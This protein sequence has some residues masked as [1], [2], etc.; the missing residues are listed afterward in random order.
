MSQPVAARIN[1]YF[2]EFVSGANQFD[3]G[4]MCCQAADFTHNIRA[5]S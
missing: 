1:L 3:S 5:S 4:P 2:V